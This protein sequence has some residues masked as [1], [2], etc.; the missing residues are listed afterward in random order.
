MK[1]KAKLIDEKSENEILLE[2]E[3]LN[4]PLSVVS[5]WVLPFFSGSLFA[6]LCFLWGNGTIAFEGCRIGP[7]KLWFFEMLDLILKTLRAIR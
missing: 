1:V 4:V 3:Q 5:N 2:T 7:R 6:P